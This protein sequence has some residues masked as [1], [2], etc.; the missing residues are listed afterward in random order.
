M[1]CTGSIWSKKVSNTLEGWVGWGTSII[2]ATWEAM[3]EGSLSEADLEQKQ[4]TLS[5]K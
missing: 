3:V 1:I 2:P 4:E 5:E